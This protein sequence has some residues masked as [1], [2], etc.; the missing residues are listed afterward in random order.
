VKT[1][2]FFVALLVAHE[3]LIILNA[4]PVMLECQGVPGI[5]TFLV[6]TK[7]NGKLPANLKNGGKEFGNQYNWPIVM[8]S[9]NIFITDLIRQIYSRAQLTIIT[10]CNVFLPSTQNQSQSI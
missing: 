4:T 8:N 6:A 7:K 1:P 3:T 5:R 9:K 10:R 2:V